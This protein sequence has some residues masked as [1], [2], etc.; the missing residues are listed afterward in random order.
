MQNFGLIGGSNGTILRTPDGG[1]SWAQ[2]AT[3]LTD[4]INKIYAPNFLIGYAVGDN[5]VIL[6]RRDASGLKE[7]NSEDIRIYPNP[8]NHIL[9]LEFNA[10]QSQAQLSIFNVSGQEIMSRQLENNRQID[11]SSLSSGIYFVAIRSENKQ[12]WTKL[13][14]E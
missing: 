9:H 13:L 7:A 5:G 11:I 2:E 8:A 3:N 6:K 10:N 14:V 1:T 12:S 4:N